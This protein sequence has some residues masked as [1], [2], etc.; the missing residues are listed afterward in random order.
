MR[1]LKLRPEVVAATLPLTMGEDHRPAPGVEELR[2]DDAFRVLHQLRLEGRTLAESG[3]AMYGT[4][5]SAAWHALAWPEPSARLVWELVAIAI[6][7]SVC[8]YFY[9]AYMVAV[10]R[11]L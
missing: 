8:V 3:S 6:E 9:A 1:S 10:A 7:N 11:K 4:W 2:V 5:I